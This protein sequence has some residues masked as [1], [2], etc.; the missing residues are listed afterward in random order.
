MVDAI[1][2]SQL[3]TQQK[4]SR[5]VETKPEREGRHAQMASATTSCARAR[6][7]VTLAHHLSVFPLMK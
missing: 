1:P 7:G 3:N 4:N 2:V 6:H 5:V